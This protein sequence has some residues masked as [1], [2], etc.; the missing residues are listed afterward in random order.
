MTKCEMLSIFAT[1]WCL[2]EHAEKVEKARRQKA[3][4]KKWQQSGFDSLCK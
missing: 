3:V 4:I 1:P 2:F